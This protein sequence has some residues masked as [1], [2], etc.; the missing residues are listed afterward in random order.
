M[1]AVRWFIYV[2]IAF[3]MILP[4]SLLAQG[5]KINIGNLKVIPGIAGQTIYDDNIYM[6]NGTTTG[7]ND[8]NTKI[9][10]WIYHVQPSLLL[11]YTF[12]ERGF[13]NL[14]YQGDW[15]FY[16]EN[17][18]NNWKNNKGFL[19]LDY[20]APGGMI[21]GI[22]NLYAASEDP[23]GS[24]D[25][26][27][28]GRTTSRWDNDLKTKFGFLFSEKFRSLLY[29]NNYKQEYKDQADAGQ[30]YNDN[31]FGIGLEAK[32]LPKTWGF[33]RYHYGKRDFDA[34][35][36]TSAYKANSNWHKT[37]AGLTWDAA[38]KLSG[39]L[40]VG[41][42]WKSYD[43]EYYTATLKR[44]KSIDTWVAATS[45]SYKPIE[46]TNLTLNIARTIRDTGADTGEYFEDT[47]YGLSLQQTILRKL[48]FNLG[49]MYSINEYNT[50]G[51]QD[52]NYSANTG[53]DYKIQ[54]WVT[55][56]VGYNYK[57]KD[58]NFKVNEYTDNQFIVSLKLVY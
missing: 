34:A 36:V 40:N 44:K 24:P 2:L 33:L 16:N 52:T 1:S 35:S 58:S 31:E 20:K 48:V 17:S 47:G 30:N 13:L 42:M 49:G 8:P 55:V 43:N 6:K 37:S 29:Y 14:G 39:E 41:Y 21:L 53:L 26:Y 51:R 32:F 18:R 9:S 15:A 11:N 50:N 5:G 10:D 27:G 3:L 25:Q 23:F 12:P 7:K 28:I 22:N 19:A 4:S 56:G 38:A 45:I 57:K 46:T 54:D